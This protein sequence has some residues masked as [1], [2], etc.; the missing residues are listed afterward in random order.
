MP[1]L[2]EVE[3]VLR[4]LEHRIKGKTIQDVIV[5]YDGIIDGDTDKFIKTLKGQTFNGFYRRGKYLI[6]Q[7]DTC[8]FVSHLRMEGKYFIKQKE[9]TRSKH[10]HVVF[11]FEDGSELRYHDTRKF[12]RM[13]LYP[14]D[15]D[16]DSFH[17]LGVEPNSDLFTSDYVY[18]I[19]KT[20][21]MPLKTLLLK[22]DFIAGIGNIYADEILFAVGLRP[23]RNC[24]RIRHVD[25]N[26]IVSE[27]N[28]I[29]KEAIQA[30]GTTI[31]TY[32]ALDGVHGRFQLHCMV[33][34]QKVC[35]V[36]GLKIHMKRI[37]G[38]SSYYCPNCQK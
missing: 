22:Q 38:R 33:H 11:Q 19:C 4:S 27:T 15:L 1:E 16:F 13:E 3:T 26:R 24:K 21:D 9:E 36:C 20:R 29:I 5:Y 37:G 23:G 28:R 35:K 7:M 31:R 18:R 14:L 17:H 25:A 2:P 6:F 10:E 34:E 8:Y 12:G 32:T 30:G